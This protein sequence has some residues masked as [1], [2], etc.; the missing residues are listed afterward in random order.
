MV[1][2][3]LQN[4]KFKEDEEQQQEE[5]ITFSTLMVQSCNISLTE[6][7]RVS[8]ELTPDEYFFEWSTELPG[9]IG[10]H[11]KKYYGPWSKKLKANQTVFNNSKA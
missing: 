10:D 3:L 7:C 6:S 4:S 2:S 11:L 9:F 1:K 5:F 8:T